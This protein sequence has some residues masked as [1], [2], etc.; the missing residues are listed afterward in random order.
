L[1]GA[2]M[3]G[4]GGRMAVGDGTLKFLHASSCLSLNDTYFS[5]MRSAMRKAGSSK[6][7]H[8]M[9]GFHGLM[10]I[11]SSF[12]GDYRDTATDGHVVSVATSWVTN[13][14]KSNNRGCASYDPFNWSGT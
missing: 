3:G 5:G 9:T 11:S 7:L 4:A 2:T 1:C 6:G 10:W 14:Y 12:N 13:H 8:V